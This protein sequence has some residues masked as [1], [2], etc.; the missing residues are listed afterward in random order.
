MGLLTKIDNGIQAFKSAFSG[1]GDDDL[2]GL[3]YAR[4]ENGSHSYNY[5]TERFGLLG[6]LGLGSP[7]EKPIENLKYYY[8][9][10]LF[11]QDCIN[12]Y[13]D[14]ASQVVIKEVDERGE[15]VK[16][17]EYVRFLSNPNGFQNQVDFIKEMVINLLATGASFQYGNFFKNGNLKISPQLYNLDFNNLSFPKIENRYALSRKDIQELPIKEHIANGK[18]RPLKMYELAF[19]YDTIPYNGF[20]KNE[21]NASDFYK[22]MSRVFSQIDSIRTLMNTQSSMSHMSGHNVNKLISKSTSPGEKLK[23]LPGDQKYDIEQ[24]LNGFG[25]Y[26][27]KRGKAGD[28]IATNETLTVSDLTRDG[29]KMQ[30]IEMQSNAKDNVRNCF[31]I[32]QDFFGDSTYENKQWSESRFILGQVKTITDNWLNEL[33]HKS[34]GY[35]EARKTKLIGTYDHIGSVA[36]TVKRL[37][38]EKLLSENKAFQAKTEALISMMVAFEQMKLIIPGITW[39]EFCNDNDFNKFLKA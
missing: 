25:R 39:D 23:A 19:F 16:N 4:L 24:K 14:F 5:E 10:T 13:A 36:E 17:S 6:L 31:L 9:K 22:P 21:Y 26:G 27:M 38:N 3:K 33:T 18:T 15:E 30:M 32:P 35:F 7:F 2:L 34:P 28:I 37:E 12:F 20:G 29:R 1:D 11:L 8:T